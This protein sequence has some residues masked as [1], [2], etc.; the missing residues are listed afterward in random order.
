MLTAGWYKFS[1]LAVLAC[2][3]LAIPAPW[4]P[5]EHVLSHVGNICHF[6]HRTAHYWLCKAPS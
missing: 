1:T 5:C 2:K 4:E 6:E 3:Y